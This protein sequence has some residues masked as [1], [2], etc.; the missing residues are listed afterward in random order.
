[1]DADLD[2]GVTPEARNM[3]E[4]GDF[5]NNNPDANSAIIKDRRVHRRDL[6]PGPNGPRGLDDP[7]YEADHADGPVTPAARPRPPGRAAASGANRAARVLTGAGNVSLSG[8]ATTAQRLIR[9]SPPVVPSN[10]VRPGGRLIDD[11]AGVG[12]SALRARPPGP[13]RP[14][15]QTV[16]EAPQSILRNPRRPLGAPG[17]RR[18]GFADQRPQFG[19]NGPGSPSDIAAAAEARAAAARVAREMAGDAPDVVAQTLA[20]TNRL[21]PEAA[22]ELRA[23]PG[24]THMIPV[25]PYA[26]PPHVRGTPA[27]SYSGPRVRPPPLPAPSRSRP[28]PVAPTA[29]PLNL[30]STVLPQLPPPQHGGRT[31]FGGATGVGNPTKGGASPE[32]AARVAA[33]TPA[34]ASPEGLPSMFLP[35][36]ETPSPFHRGRHR[37]T[38]RPPPVTPTTSAFR[39]QVGAG[40]SGARNG[41]FASPTRYSPMGSDSPFSPAQSHGR[42]AFSTGPPSSFGGVSLEPTAGTPRSLIRALPTPT[43]LEHARAATEA[44]RYKARSAADRAR[45]LAAQP[46]PT[47]PRTAIR[48]FVGPTAPTIGSGPRRFASPSPNRGPGGGGGGAA[49]G[50]AAKSPVGR[51][52]G[53]SAKFVAAGAQRRARGRAMR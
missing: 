38:P 7:Y 30:P 45:H 23:T 18:V 47:T 48:N 26:T 16:E 13:G 29:A 53:G 49:R 42:V 22:S 24:G 6:F 34:R 3:Q 43:P 8:A 11:G 12:D 39:A 25:P 52:A 4:A 15:P 51:L 20:D 21:R 41:A 17:G 46:A 28:P 27:P 36:D 19:R 10:G 1:M 50:L 37:A 32:M 31:Y 35:Q 33:G 9:P 2:A 5:Y 44:A 40:F 14:R